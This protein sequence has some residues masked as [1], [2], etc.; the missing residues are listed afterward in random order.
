MLLMGLRLAEG[1]DLDVMARRFGFAPG[2][3]ELKDLTNLGLIE[4]LEDEPDPEIIRAC[5][6]PG[7]RP[8]G[9]AG[10]YRRR[11]AVRA[12]GSGRFV[13]NELVRRLSLSMEAVHPPALDSPATLRT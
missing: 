1:V 13:L 7:V 8:A 10:G 9:P 4:V 5:V 6:G 3:S 12:A 2:I 11:P